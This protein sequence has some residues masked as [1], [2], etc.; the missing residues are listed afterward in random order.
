MAMF[1]FTPGLYA[2]DGPIDPNPPKGISIDSI[3][4]KFA[5]KEKEFAQARE[6]YTFR[7]SVLIQ[8]L[9]GD[10]AV[11]EF[12]EIVDVVFDDHGKR[13]ENVVF[14]PQP[15]FRN[16]SMD[17]EDFDDI[18]HRYPFVLTTDDIPTYQILYVGHEKVD[19]LTTYVFDL[20]P[21]KMEKGKRYFQGRIWVDDQD[22]QIVK[23]Q[24]KPVYLGMEH[25]QH[26]YLSFTTYR[27]QI[28]GHYWFPTYTFSDEVL[29]FPGTK[30]T[31]PQDAHMR[32]KIK[33]TDYKQFKSKSRIIFD[34]QDVKREDQTQTPPQSQPPA[35]QAP[36]PDTPK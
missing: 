33:Y 19:E 25:D 30:N 10:T 11:G 36:P 23:T 4:Q 15:S 24:G 26:Q 20:A 22:L 8:E 13:K 31:P 9:D 17:Q 3:I 16:V 32:L 35:D 34:G 29:H 21:K 18:E 7:Q 14:A 5:A 27:E 2:Q 1:A 6:N 28:D 12:R